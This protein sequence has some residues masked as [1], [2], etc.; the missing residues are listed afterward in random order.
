[1]ADVFVSYSRRDADRVRT[2]SGAVRES[3]YSVWW[4]EQLLPASDY[5]QVIERELAAAGSVL[6]AWSATAR[7]SLWVRAEANEALDQGKLVQVTLDGAKLPLPFTAL[8]F[9]DFTR[10]RGERAGRPWSDLEAGLDGTRRGEGE[11][12]P[13]PSAR[14]PALQGLGPVTAL[15]WAAL[16]LAFLLALAAGAAATGALPTAYF[17]LFAMYGL[18]SAAI[19]LALVTWRT[20]RVLQ[21]SRR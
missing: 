15:G 17:G 4:D 1:M 13:T 6:V 3:G 2:L 19:L 7:E 9:L 5:A 18:A 11:P 21:A 10:W 14:E 16:A 8:H 20:A 12:A